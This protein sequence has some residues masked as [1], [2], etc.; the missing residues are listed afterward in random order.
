MNLSR[1]NH[2]IISRIV[3]S[4]SGDKYLVH[5]LMIESEFGVEC[6]VLSAKKI[7]DTVYIAGSILSP[8][9]FNALK[10]SPEYKAR[11]IPNFSFFKSQPTRAPSLE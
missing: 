7:E 11:I 4:E 10:I 2:S 5:F 8:F 3:T 9:V 6:K 1:I